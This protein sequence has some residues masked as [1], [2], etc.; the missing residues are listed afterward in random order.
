MRPPKLGRYSH[1][2]LLGSP[3]HFVGQLDSDYF[4]LNHAW[5]I[6]HRGGWEANP[7]S[8][9][10]RAF[11]TVS[12]MNKERSE[13]RAKFVRLPELSYVGDYFCVFLSVLFGKRFQNL[14][15]LE[16]NGNRRVP[17]VAGMRSCRLREALPFSSKVRKDLGF[18]LKLDL[19]K[20]MLP[21]LDLVFREI[22]ENASLSEDV[23][24]AYT[25]G[26]FYLQGLDLFEDDSELSYLSFV[27]A[28][29]VLVS[30]L[31]FSGKELYD[32]DT[33][34]LLSHVARKAGGQA[35]RAVRKK[36][37]QVRRRFRIGL[38]R[39]VAPAFFEG[40]ECSEEWA[41]LKPE[42]FGMRLNAA[43]DLRSKFLHSG[44]RFAVWAEQLRHENAEIVPG[45]PA[46]GTPEWKELIS[47]IP[48]LLAVERVMRF[49]LLKFIHTRIT[50][51]ATKLG[52][53][54]PVPAE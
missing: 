48:T 22:D 41:A 11:F 25:A 18:E 29:E 35:A 10:Y 37:F 46:H 52:E 3:V 21:L 24:L 47:R 28:G 9:L 30:A 27:N 36:L 33:R 16:T 14:G 42:D 2:L 44:A 40:H 15:F 39:L 32:S 26:R 5:P 53:A 12:F 4:E 49:C 8:P 45:K 31:S 20:P 6:G 43:Y 13:D 1:V 19:A 51:L 17:D 38:T 50:P 23:E 34:K 7:Q 54:S